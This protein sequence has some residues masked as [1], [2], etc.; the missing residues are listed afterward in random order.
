MSNTENRDDYVSRIG[1][2]VK[3]MFE[4]LNVD[5]KNVDVSTFIWD[6]IEMFGKR[7]FEDLSEEVD[8]DTDLIDLDEFEP[9]DELD[10]LAQAEEE[11]SVYDE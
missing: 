6:N 10:A 11:A 2:V 4:D 5:P 9:A 1:D 8:M 7:I 3:Q